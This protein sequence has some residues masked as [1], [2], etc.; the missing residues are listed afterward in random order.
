MFF[1]GFVR[2]FHLTFSYCFFEIIR[3]N[4]TFRVHENDQF[5]QRYLRLVKKRK[6]KTIILFEYLNRVS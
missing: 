4:Q 1:V 5:I 3:W 6:K 2:I